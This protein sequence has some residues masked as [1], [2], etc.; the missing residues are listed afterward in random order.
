M[1]PAL[2]AHNIQSYDVGICVPAGLVV[3][4]RESTGMCSGT[5]AATAPEH[6]RL[7]MLNAR[8]Y[9]SPQAKI[10]F[11]KLLPSM[12]PVRELEAE[13][14]L[15]LATVANASSQLQRCVRSRMR[16]ILLGRVRTV[17]IIIPKYGLGLADANCLATTI[18][19]K[20]SQEVGNL[21]QTMQICQKNIVVDIDLR[22]FGFH[23][24][25]LESAQRIPQWKVMFE[26]LLS[27]ISNHKLDVQLFGNR[28]CSL[29]C[30]RSTTMGIRK[31]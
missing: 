26:E 14:N 15:M 22:L 12:L 28:R 19:T 8:P 3:T 13:H 23:H 25:A 4:C 1:H 5:D 29:T 11:S 6:M 31:D 18:G 21:Q 24:M 20:N 10:D 16:L 7:P 17:R 27:L 2:S 30:A 9:T